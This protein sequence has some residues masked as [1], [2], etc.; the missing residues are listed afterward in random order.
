MQLFSQLQSFIY[1]DNSNLNQLSNS[2]GRVYEDDYENYSKVVDNNSSE[3][4]NSSLNSTI[5][6]SPI[7]LL[8]DDTPAKETTNL[9]DSNKLDA[10]K[11]KSPLI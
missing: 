2:F 7:S 5:D 1:F 4:V 3:A 9:L 6:A 11:V 8:K 10:N